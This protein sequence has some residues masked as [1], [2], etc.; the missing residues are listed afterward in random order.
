MS[1]LAGTSNQG[2]VTFTI[3]N[4]STQIAGPFT[5]SVANGVASGN[6][7]VPAGTTVGSYIIEAVYNGTQSYAESLPGTSKL[8]ISAAATTTTAAATSTQFSSASQSV[9]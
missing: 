9:D 2:S 6:V 1:S 7:S 4:G 3:L 5:L 8:T